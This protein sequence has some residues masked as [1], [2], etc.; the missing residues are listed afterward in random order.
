MRD[1]MATSATKAS[2]LEKR[3]AHGNAMRILPEDQTILRRLRRLRDELHG[4]SDPQVI[5]LVLRR[6]ADSLTE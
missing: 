3:E 2:K 5:R 6:Y 4:L 1:R